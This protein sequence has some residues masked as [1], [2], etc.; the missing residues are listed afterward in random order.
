[1]SESPDRL[2]RFNEAMAPAHAAHDAYNLACAAGGD[3]V[4]EYTAYVE[5]RA[6]CNQRF[7]DQERQREAVRLPDGQTHEEPQG[8]A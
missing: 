6:S 5:L 7:L 8:A 4:A 1:M 2:D 3:G